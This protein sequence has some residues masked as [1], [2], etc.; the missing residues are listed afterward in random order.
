M[1]IRFNFHLTR[2]SRFSVSGFAETGTN[3]SY[4]HVRFRVSM[5]YQS[6]LILLSC[7]SSL[8]GIPG[9][10]SKFGLL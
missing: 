9:Q 2:N 4:R 1:Q 6:G 10:G 5:P 3:H 7:L 8:T